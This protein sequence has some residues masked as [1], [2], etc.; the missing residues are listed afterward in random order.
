MFHPACSDGLNSCPMCKVRLLVLLLVLLGSTLPAQVAVDKKQSVMIEAEIQE[1]P[2]RITLKWAEDLENSGYTIYRKSKGAQ[3]WGN[4]LGSTLPSATSWEDNQVQ[5]GTGYEYRVVKNLAGYGGGSSAG[6]LYAGIKMPLVHD[7]GSCILVIEESLI[8]PLAMEISRLQQD[9]V[10]EGWRVRTI[11]VEREEAVTAVKAKIIAAAAGDNAFVRT[12]FLLG[13]VP[14]P[15]SGNTAPDGHQP[16]HLGAWPCDG[17]YGD[18]DGNWTDV[19]VNNAGAAD[20]RNRNIPGDGKF[21][22]NVIPTLLELGVGRVDF[23]NLLAFPLSEVELLRRYLNK[24][25]AWRKGQTPVQARGLVQNN[26]PAL[27]EGFGQNG[28]KNMA[29]LL[30]ND[31]VFELPY[32]STLQQ[33]PYLWSYGAGP[34]SYTSASGIVNTTNLTTDSL[35][36]IF[37]ML[38]GSYFGDWDSN[39]NLLRAALAS[40]QTLTNAWAGRPNWMFHHMGLGDPIGYSARISMS[41]NGTLYQSGI[42]P[43]GIHMALMGDPTLVLHPFLQPQQL[44]AVPAGLGIQLSWSPVAGAL[45]YHIYRKADGSDTF[46]RLTSSD[47]LSSTSFLDPCPGEGLLT[48]QVRAIELRQTGSGSYYNAGAAATIM[49]GH[50]YEGEQ[51]ISQFSPDIQEDLF[52][53]S[54]QSIRATSFLWQFGDGNTSAEAEPSH[55]YEDSGTYLVCLIARDACLADT[56]CQE[57]SALNSL[58]QFTAQLTAPT[59][60]PGMDGMIALSLQGGDP[61]PQILWSN[62]ATGP[63][64]SGLAAGEYA[65]TVTTYTDKTA[66][67]GP[68]LLVPDTLALS[69]TIEPAQAGQANGQITLAVQGGQPPYSFQWCT[70][71]ES[72]GEQ[73]AI[74]LGAGTCCVTVT[75]QAGCTSTA[76]YTVEETT[77]L[78]EWNGVRLLEMYPNPT[79]GLIHIRLANETG[80]RVELSLLDMWGRT[81]LRETVE[82]PEIRPQWDLKTLPAGRYWLVVRR[83]GQVQRWPLDRVRGGAGE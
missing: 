67:W 14:V 42:A 37:T 19:A 4:A 44:S 39:N 48:Y 25:H 28:W 51:A 2:P 26:F 50:S 64:I 27:A 21:D 60:A 34:G 52:L 40:G 46:E 58:P 57:I 47:P 69:P 10:E 62:G 23:A 24:N 1:N 6:Y 9:L 56:S 20:P 45:G 30:G 78:A 38:F 74:L 13:R 53:P 79:S 15:Y 12:L 5:P 68:W 3:S 70:G 7:R 54:N 71:E 18:L 43:M 82:G 77:A 22:Q 81:V 16:D 80:G 55:L 31:A 33:E 73:A 63:V 29:A 59:C 35:Q 17:Y 66:T 11:L 36:T 75:D 41:N 49:V 32:R 61:N 65:C 72:T 76:C 8:T 83:D